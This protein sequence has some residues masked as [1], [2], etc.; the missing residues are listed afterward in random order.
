MT[1]SFFYKIADHVLKVNAPVRFD[2]RKYL[3]SFKDF[4]I[5][6]LD[7]DDSVLLSVNI[8][9]DSI[10]SFESPVNVLADKSV[11]WGE[12]FFFGE[13][14]GNYLTT[15]KSVDG[16]SKVGMLSSSEF[17]VSTIYLGDAEESYL[18]ILSWF[19]MVVFGQGILPFHT[20]LI[21]A[22]VVEHNQ[23]EAYAF[24]G[25]SGTGKSTHSQLWLK[26]LKGFQL[27]N[28]D[29]PAVRV[30]DDKEVFVY[31]TPWSGKTDCYRDLKVRLEGFIRLRQAGFNKFSL[32]KDTE[33]LI[34][35]LPSCTAIRWNK[36]L[37]NNMVNTIEKILSIIPMGVMDCQINE[38]AAN[39]SYN[40]IQLKTISYE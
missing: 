18:N 10:P 7:S 1:K 16:R 8:S 11:V 38:E 25:K 15:M 39:I 20:V 33:S 36:N 29:N 40:G 19:L 23:E 12:G 28:D 5:I 22:S 35:L 2:L 6:E 13:V 21:H 30:F 17:R 26:Y 24:L 4:E 9:E 37:F 14:E 32:V 31:G 27:L 3:P 34:S